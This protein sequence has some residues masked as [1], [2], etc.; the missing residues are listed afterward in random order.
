MKIVRKIKDMQSYSRQQA[1]AGKLIGFVPTMG[2]LHDGHLE[3][4]R[5]AR[6]ECDAVVVSIFVNPTQ[7]APGEDYESYPR[8]E[9]RDLFLLEKEGVDAVFVPAVEE[10]YPGKPLTRVSVAEMTEPMCGRYR[11]GHFDGVTTVVAKLFNIVLPHRAYFGEKDY[12]QLKVIEKMVEDLNFPVDIVPVPTVREAD[13]LA[14][15]SRNTY[16]NDEERRAAP[17]IFKA[18]TQAEQAFRAGERSADRLAEIVRQE[19]EANP[20][21]RLQYVEVRDAETLEEINT[22]ERPAVIAVAAYLG[23]ARLI[24]NIVIGREE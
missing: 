5:R 7:F 3:L 22:V 11:P 2:Y 24:D 16:L 13:G 12:Q 17:L 18:L 19:I 23:K 8:D 10:M 14:M 4:V 6:Q 20:L 9:A 21:F 15:S 1:E